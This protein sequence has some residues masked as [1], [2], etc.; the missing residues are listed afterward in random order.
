[1]AKHKKIRADRLAALHRECQGLTRGQRTERMQKAAELFGVSLATLYRQLDKA[2]LGTDR[3]RNASKANRPEL[4][5]WTAGMMLLASK[6]PDGKFIPLIDARIA[7]FEAGYIPAQALDEPIET[8]HRIAREM[9]FRETDRKINSVWANHAHEAVEFD[10]SS[11][12]YFSVVKELEDGDYL[13]KIN[14]RPHAD[15]KNKPVGKDRLRVIIYSF[16]EMYSGHQWATYTVSTGENGYDGMAALIEYATPKNDPR[17]PVHGLMDQLWADQG[18]V[19][20]LGAS[21][22]LIERLGIEIVTGEAYAKERMGGVEQTHRRRWEFERGL[23]MTVINRAAAKEEGIDLATLTPPQR[24]EITLSE[25][26]ARCASHRAR[27]NA[28]PARWQPGKSKCAAWSHSAAE[29]ARAGNPIR[30]IPENAIETMATEKRCRCDQYGVIRWDNRFY[31]VEDGVHSRWMIARRSLDD[32]SR[33]VVE[34]IETGKRYSTRPFEPRKLGEYRT[35]PATPLQK[36]RE[37]GAT[38]SAPSPYVPAE[39]GNVVAMPAR[40]RAPDPLPNPL[41]AGRYGSL[42]EALRAFMDWHGMPNFAA[43]YPEEFDTAVEL[44]TDSG[45][46][47]EYVRRLALDLRQAVKAEGQ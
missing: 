14:P 36:A 5:E 1:M 26:N 27:L 18:P 44:I 24:G 39:G 41:D 4:R 30:K 34:D 8:F 11:S 23:Y 28:R 40:T 37:L 45:L 3:D 15:Y 20:K 9:G 31:E 38:L 2:G 17:D 21:V 33:V 10:A 12:A 29:R 19:T 6:S 46:Q 7:A 47:K 22:D 25:L 42:G 13:L 32:P 16:W 35:I 43:D